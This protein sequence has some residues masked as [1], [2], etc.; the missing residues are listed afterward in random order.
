MAEGERDRLERMPSRVAVRYGLTPGGRH[1]APHG[2]PIAKIGQ[3]MAARLPGALGE[4]V[5]GQFGVDRLK[6]LLDSIATV[7]R[8]G[9]VSISGVY[10]GAI[11]P[12][13][14]LDMF[15]MGIQI[16]MGQ[17]HVRRWIAE[18]MPYLEDDTDPLGTAD[19]A[20]HY[21]PLDRAPRATR[22]SRRRPTAAPRS[23]SSPAAPSRRYIRVVRS[24][25]SSLAQSDSRRSAGGRRRYS[26]TSSPS[27]PG[28][29][30]CSAGPHAGGRVRIL[31]LEDDLAVERALTARRHERLAGQDRQDES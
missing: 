12:L 14:M 30:G 28:S 25:T 26:A 2:N 9:T 23:F 6:G 3:E 24:P 16:R 21:L 11:D 31:V 29:G 17:C 4:K 1:L 27:P 7:R 19:M 13:P 10:G 8:G 22:S 15:D 5:A 20:S 18:I